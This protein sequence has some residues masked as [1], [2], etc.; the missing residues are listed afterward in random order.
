MDY[1]EARFRKQANGCHQQAALAV[2]PLDKDAWLLLADD[3]IKMAQAAS[4]KGTEQ[5]HGPSFQGKVIEVAKIRKG[6]PNQL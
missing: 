1:S 3:W 4:F 2:N 6:Q 5:N